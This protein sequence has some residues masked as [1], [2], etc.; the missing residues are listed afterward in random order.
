MK[1]QYRAMVDT[2]RLYNLEFAMSDEKQFESLIRQYSYKHLYNLMHRIWKT[3][4]VPI[5]PP[6][7]VF[8]D[9]MSR[10]GSLYS[11]YYRGVI[12]L[13]PDQ[14]NYMTLIHEMVHAM[15]YEKH[16]V[17]FVEMY[18]YLLCTYTNAASRQVINT[19]KKLFPE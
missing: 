7:L 5:I 13:A 11:W 1:P 17:M 6:T 19:F 9:G 2:R 3:E 8:G 12:H 14:H 4:N 15:G 10:G 16:D 18:V